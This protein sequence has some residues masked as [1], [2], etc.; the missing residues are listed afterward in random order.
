VQGR[1][2]PLP[3]EQGAERDTKDYV[4]VVPE[5]WELLD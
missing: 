4:G 2:S 3:A 1:R 5:V